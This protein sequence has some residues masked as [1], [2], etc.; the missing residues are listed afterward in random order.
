VTANATG[1]TR[2]VVET[3]VIDAAG[4][5]YML[6]AAQGDIYNDVWRSADQG[7][8][9]HRLATRVSRDGDRARAA[10][11]TWTRMTANATW[12]ARAEYT[13][14]VDAAGNI[15]VLGG[16]SGLSHKC[17]GLSPYDDMCN[18]VWRSADQGAAP[19][20]LATHTAYQPCALRACAC[21]RAR[22]CVRVRVCACACVCV[23]ACVCAFKCL[24]TCA[25]VGGCRYL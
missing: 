23:R 17:P 24:H 3:S 25:S 1:T 15:Y 14:V 11:A 16:E 10:G 9:P 4:N 7:A 5:I 18:D 21:V 8:A 22:V 13:A 2:Y 19:H 6:G 12:G 20:R